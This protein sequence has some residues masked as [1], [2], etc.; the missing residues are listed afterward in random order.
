MKETVKQQTI[1][2]G[3][4]N[5]FNDENFSSIKKSLNEVT[6]ADMPMQ[7]PKSSKSVVTGTS[8]N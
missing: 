4:S 3:A 5:N 2:I 6:Y 7:T 1:A 8:K